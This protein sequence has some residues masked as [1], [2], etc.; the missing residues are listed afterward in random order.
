[1]NETFRKFGW[2][3]TK[4]AELDHW[5]I[6]LRPEQPTLGSLVLACK[7][8]VQAFSD[9]DAGGY[10]ELKQAVDGIE[11]MLKGVVA[12]QKINYLMLMM[13][14]PDVHFH[15]VPR[16]DGSRTLGDLSITDVGWPGPPALGSATALSAAEIQLLV[17]LFSSR[18]Q[19]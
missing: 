19:R 16:Y 15:V 9:V 7:Q 18:W 4:I 5:G 6:M 10:A 2:P 14:D 3:A 12:Y 17:G 11:T 1:M 8:H 13:V